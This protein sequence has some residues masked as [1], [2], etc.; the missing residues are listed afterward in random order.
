ML[1]C[2]L[3]SICVFVFMLVIH[4]IM[5]VPQFPYGGKNKPGTWYGLTYG[6]PMVVILGGLASS[7]STKC[8]TQIPI[9]TPGNGDGHGRELANCG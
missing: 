9:T 4:F 1:G 6:S 5:G 8:T 2:G 7:R 3:G